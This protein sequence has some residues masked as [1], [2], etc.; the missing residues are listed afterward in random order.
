MN[1]HRNTELESIDVHNG[2][3]KYPIKQCDFPY[4]LLRNA[5]FYILLEFVL[6]FMKVPFF[7][8]M[9]TENVFSPLK[10]LCQPQSFARFNFSGGHFWYYRNSES[11]SKVTE[12]AINP[13]HLNSIKLLISLHLKIRRAMN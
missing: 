5:H 8:S 10:N 1:L 2:V 11:W 12:S 7:Y 13:L 6:K 9:E 3:M 4:F